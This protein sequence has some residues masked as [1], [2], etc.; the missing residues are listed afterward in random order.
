M[1]PCLSLHQHEKFKSEG[2]KPFGKFSIPGSCR[3]ES[4]FPVTKIRNLRWLGKSQK[5]K[6]VTIITF[7]QPPT[8]R[9]I[10][11]HFFGNFAFE[12]EFYANFTPNSTF[13]SYK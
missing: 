9:I 5:S 4:H 6:K 2:G 11:K 10:L 1:I 3:K 13:R 8:P 7:F 12:S